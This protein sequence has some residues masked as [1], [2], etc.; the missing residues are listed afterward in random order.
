MTIKN[1]SEPGGDKWVVNGVLE[2]TQEGNL[3]I[4][5]LPLK[6]IENQKESAA[7]TIADLKMDFNKLIANLKLAGLMEKDNE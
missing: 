1:Y 4:N 6:S 5:G 2:I 3:L 7:T